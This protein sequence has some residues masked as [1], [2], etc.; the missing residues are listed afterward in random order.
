M[1]FTTAGFKVIFFCFLI[2]INLQTYQTIF[3]KK[4][5]IVVSPLLISH[6]LSTAYPGLNANV[7]FYHFLLIIFKPILTKFYTT[8]KHFL[9]NKTVINIVLITYSKI[10]V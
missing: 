5:F 7:D 2:I 10:Y 4:L 1:F 8:D 6:H 9:S 3:V